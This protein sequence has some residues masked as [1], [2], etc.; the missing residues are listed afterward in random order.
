MF[1]LGL[2]I[3]HLNEVHNFV[4]VAV[5]DKHEQVPAVCS[6]APLPRIFVRLT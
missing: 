4:I 3:F 1:G 6:S 2:Y 5:A